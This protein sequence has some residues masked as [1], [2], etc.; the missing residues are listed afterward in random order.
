[1]NLDLFPQ[2]D[3]LKMINYLLMENKILKEKI[4]Y[5]EGN[6]NNFFN[7]FENYKKIMNLNFVYNSLDTNAHTLDEIFSSLQSNI[8]RRREE[9]VLINKEIFQL[10][11]R[12]II[13]LLLKYNSK[14]DHLE[15]SEIKKR[16]QNNEY[17]IVFI[18]TKDKKRFGAFFNNKNPNDMKIDTMLNKNMNNGINKKTMKINRNDNNIYRPMGV[19]KDENPMMLQNPVFQNIFSFKNLNNCF[20]FSLDELKI[21][22]NLYNNIFRILYDRRRK[23]I[24]GKGD[25][26]NTYNDLCEENEFGIECCEL[27]EIIF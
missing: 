15:P 11:K 22:N 8:I 23:E 19:F 6:L 14:N 17:S 4:N 26:F 18:C 7:E 13:S 10:F 16:F 3:S 27:Y 5:L 2:N 12:N 9:F 21:Y 1:M 25:P 24:F 20:V